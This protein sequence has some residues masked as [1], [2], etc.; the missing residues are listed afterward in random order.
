MRK[1]AALALCCGM[2]GCGDGPVPAKIISSTL[3]DDSSRGSTLFETGDGQRF[4]AS[5][6]WG[7]AGDSILLRPTMTGRYRWP[8]THPPR[9]PAKKTHPHPVRKDYTRKAVR[10]MMDDMNDSTISS[11][12]SA[13]CI[14]TAVFICELEGKVLCSFNLSQGCWYTCCEED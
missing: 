10:Q 2:V 13:L 7:K 5:Y 1:V 4:M 14:E 12:D 6:Y 3:P 8:S 11:E 9:E